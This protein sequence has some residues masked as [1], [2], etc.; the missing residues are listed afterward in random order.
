M[1]RKPSRM[2]WRKGDDIASRPWQGRL[3]DYDLFKELTIGVVVVGLLVC[4]LSAV[5]SSPDEPGV[6]LKSWATAAPADFVATA[7]RELGGVSDTAGYGPP[8]N[9]TPAD[10]PAPLTM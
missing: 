7:T 2:S 1:D 9:A 10:S 3:R 4:G 5:F 8:Y 6:T